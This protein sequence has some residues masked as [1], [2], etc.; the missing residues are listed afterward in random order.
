MKSSHTLS[1][2]GKGKTCLWFL[3]SLSTTGGK[4]PRVA[5]VNMESL[6]S[7][8]LDG[9]SPPLQSWPIPTPPTCVVGTL[10]VPFL[11]L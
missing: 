10:R 2:W 1:K 6:W 4:C 9:V 7:K 5:L 3:A 11:Q 8:G